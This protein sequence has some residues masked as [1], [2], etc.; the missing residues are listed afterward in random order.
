MKK[1]TI[2]LSSLVAILFV[3]VLCFLYS[4]SHNKPINMSS[5]KIGITPTPNPTADWKTYENKQVGFNIKYP[6]NWN[7]LVK[8]NKTTISGPRSCFVIDISSQKSPSSDIKQFIKNTFFNNL[9]YQEVADIID[10]NYQTDKAFD[11]LRTPEFDMCGTEH[12]FFIKNNIIVDLE[13]GHACFEGGDGSGS[14]I[15]KYCSSVDDQTRILIPQILS[16]FKFTTSAASTA[17]WK[18]YENKKYKFSL[19]YPASQNIEVNEVNNDN[20]IQLIFDKSST[21]S[22]SIKASIGY[23][24][25]QSKY[26]LDTESI[27]TKNI[28][29]QLWSQFKLPN[30][31]QG[32]Q[33][34]KNAIL[35]SITYPTSKEIEVAQ[36]LSTFKFTN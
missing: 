15:E 18:N 24:V 33:L 20:Y 27:G 12:Q 2:F 5:E 13:I 23:S 11:S 28:N 16:T 31:Y 25:N 7:I 8:S 35:Y 30:N 6:N 4:N 1:S 21:G 34:E 10:R 14:D 36:I 22:F 32:L 29:G 9:N 19:N 26:L 3:A 17:D